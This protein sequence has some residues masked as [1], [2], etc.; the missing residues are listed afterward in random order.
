MLVLEPI[1]FPWPN[2][3]PYIDSLNPVKFC[4]IVKWLF[5]NT[6]NFIDYMIG[7]NVMQMYEEDSLP[8]FLQY[9]KVGR[10]EKTNP[11]FPLDLTTLWY[12][13]M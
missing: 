1:S 8:Y 11:V 13:W 12:S 3:P 2:L 10:E 7:T 5:T 6:L 9:F 4:V